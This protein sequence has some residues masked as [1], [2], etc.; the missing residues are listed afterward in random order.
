MSRFALI[1]RASSEGS[2]PSFSV[3]Q[4]SPRNRVFPYFTGKTRPLKND[5]AV[6][7]GPF[8]SILDRQ[9]A[10]KTQLFLKCDPEMKKRPQP[11][12]EKTCAKK[13]GLDHGR[14][15]LSDSPVQKENQKT[16]IQ[17]QDRHTDFPFINFLSVLN[18]EESMYLMSVP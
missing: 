7:I 14:I 8:Q 1:F 13:A 9:N 12:G 5:Q 6:H 4:K 3:F 10:T 11:A 18:F 17:E 15:F 2:N 16:D